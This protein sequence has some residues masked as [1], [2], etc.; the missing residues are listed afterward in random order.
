V[1]AKLGHPYAKYNRNLTKN[2]NG[3]EFILSE[4]TEYHNYRETKRDYL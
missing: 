4:N 3:K 2:K 1:Q